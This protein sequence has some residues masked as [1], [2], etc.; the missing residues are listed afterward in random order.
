M[1][2]KVN[3][4]YSGETT[5]ISLFKTNLRKSVKQINVNFGIQKFLLVKPN[6]YNHLD[7]RKQHFFG[8]PQKRLELCRKIQIAIIK[9]NM[10]TK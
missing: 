7:D 6:K 3:K 1:R 4:N 5:I 10:I 9:L 8:L 2:L